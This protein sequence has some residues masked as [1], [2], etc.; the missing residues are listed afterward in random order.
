MLTGKGG[1]GGG[2]EGEKKKYKKSIGTGKVSFNR[3]K[4]LK[5]KI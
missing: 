4:K 5:R 3:G 1:G 2:G